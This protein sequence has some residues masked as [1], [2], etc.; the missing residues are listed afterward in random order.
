VDAATEW[1]ASFF[2]D[3]YA[4]V[5]REHASASTS[6]TAG[7][8]G[9][10]ARVLRVEPPARLLDVPCGAGRHAVELASRG[11]ALTGVDLA[12][13]ALDYARGL[14]ASRGVSLELERRDMRVLP[15]RGT[16]DG[17]YC[18]FGSF[19]YFDDDGNQ[20]FLEAVCA[21]LKPGARFLLETHI[22]ET[23]LPRFQRQGWMRIGERLLLEER[24]YDHER[25]RI[26]TDWTLVSEGRVLQRHSSIRLY[27]YSEL[28]RR[29]E[30]AGF[31][32]TEAYDTTTQLPFH[33]NA[34]RLSIVATKAR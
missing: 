9:F 16:F 15:W 27:T 18:F 17:A 33:F 30:Q 7:E 8:A 4:E 5:Q 34:S 19:G 32:G 6:E 20:S 10:V 13:G 23:I 14:A 29:L 22:A 25:G 26:E 24:R 3:L 12:A 31:S 21:T 1:W 28:C 2:T 11:F